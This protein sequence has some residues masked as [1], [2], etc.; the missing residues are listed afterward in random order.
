DILGWFPTRDR[1]VYYLAGFAGTG[2]STVCGYAIAELQAKFSEVKKVITGAYTGKAAHV[3][4]S[5]G[6]ESAMTLHSMI[7][8]PIVDEVTGKVTFVLNVGGPASEADLIVL[9]ECSMIDEAMALDL[10]SFGKKVLVMGD[11][12]QLPPVGGAGF[13]TARRPDSFL[14][15]VHRQAAESPI[16]RV[17]TMVRQGRLPRFG[18]VGDTIVAPLTRETQ[19]A[20]YREDTQAICGTH[21]VRW[22]YTAR[23]RRRR[24]FVNPLPEWNER[25]ICTRNHAEVGLFNGMLGK[26]V[27]DAVAV[28][29][30]RFPD[31]DLCRLTVRLDD[32]ADERRDILATPYLF[33]SLYHGASERPRGLKKGIEEWDWGYVLTCHKAQGSEWPHV[34]VVD[35]SGSF[36]ADR[37]RWLYTACTRPSEGLTLLLRQ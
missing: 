7:Y 10:L 5:K 6:V 21:R 17:A 3:L 22:A 23:I 2:K 27:G 14:T 34:T 28:R 13:F 31:L 33:N 1:Q 29:E 8:S 9:D 37:W 18:Q 16:I 15:E 36:G 32:E 4:R 12:G 24:G 35:D 30:R 11:P 26:A 25:I 19:E 20:V